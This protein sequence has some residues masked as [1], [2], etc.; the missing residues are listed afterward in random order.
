MNGYIVPVMLYYATG[1]QDG[2]FS[3]SQFH[4]HGIMA[5]RCARCVYSSYTRQA[6]WLCQY[7]LYFVAIPD[8][9]LCNKREKEH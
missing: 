2:S 5:P 3:T 9:F 4:M 1:N 8:I 7:S 6:C